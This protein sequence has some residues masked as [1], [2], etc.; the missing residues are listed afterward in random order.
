MFHTSDIQPVF[1]VQHFKEVQNPQ[2]PVESLCEWYAT[3]NMQVFFRTLK[4]H[5]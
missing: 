1:S 5:L 3:R 4:P 2:T